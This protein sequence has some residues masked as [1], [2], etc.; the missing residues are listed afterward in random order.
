MTAIE[1]C[2]KCK[3]AIAEV[4]V[5]HFEKGQKKHIKLCEECAKRHNE[6]QQLA[7]V[8]QFFKKFAENMFD[9]SEASTPSA[10]CPS[11]GMTI[12]KFEVRGLLGCE[13]C[14][15]TFESEL[16]DLL[17]RIHGSHKHIG[18]RPRPNRKITTS[19]LNALQKKLKAAISA[20]DF[21][22]AAECRD[23]IRDLERELQ[24]QQN[25]E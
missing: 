4:T 25:S 3:T 2:Q 7:S 8:P 22:K 17:R 14:Y 1:M 12:G 20:E 9:S 21:E 13:Q 6:L 10:K 19:D 15:Q 23:M 5:I 18:S 16:T 24:R 11:C